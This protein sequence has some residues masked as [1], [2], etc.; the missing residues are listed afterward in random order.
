MH[1][2]RGEIIAKIETLIPYTCP[3]IDKVIKY[4]NSAQKAISRGLKTEDV[5]YFEEAE[6]D[7]DGLEDELEK[8]RTAND[9]LRNYA[10]RFLDLE[11]N[12]NYLL[13]NA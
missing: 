10:Q 6:S 3:D 7:L 4:I 5:S 2:I 11:E 1:K 13:Q 12:L 8:L 9:S